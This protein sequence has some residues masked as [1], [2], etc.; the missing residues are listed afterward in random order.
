[1]S[2]PRRHATEP[3]P[4]TGFVPRAAVAVFAIGVA[5]VVRV[6]L[7]RTL[8]GRNTFLL[9]EPAIAIAAWYGGRVSGFTATVAAVVV[10]LALYVRPEGGLPAWPDT[11][12]LLLF[13]VNGVLITLLSSGLRSA[14]QRERGARRVAEESARRNDDLQRLSLALN[15]PLAPKALAQTAIEQSVRLLGA[16][17]GVIAT[18]RSSEPKL[19]IRAGFGYTGGITSGE[20]S[21]DP[22]SMLGGVVA[23]GE[24]V[25]LRGRV[26]RASRYPDLAARFQADGDSIILPLLYQDAATGAIYLNFDGRTNYGTSDREFLRS[27]GAQCGSALER[28]LLIEQAAAM[29]VKE[30]A[31]AAELDTILESIGHAVLVANDEGQIILGNTAVQRLLGRRIERIDQLPPAAADSPTP[32]NS[33]NRYLS[34]SPIRP[35]RW[36]EVSK[37]RVKAEGESSEVALVRDV[38]QVVEVDL[39]REAF[40]GVL[41]H[42]LRTPVTS[43]LLAVDLLRRSDPSNWDRALNLLADVDAELNRLY[44]IVEDLMVL[45]RSERGVLEVATEPVLV[46]RIVHDVVERMTLGDPDVPI[47]FTSAEYLPPVE[48]EPIYVQQITR[49]LISNA[50]KYG[51]NSHH[52]IEVRIS[53]SEGKVETRVLDR[54]VGLGE[55]EADKLF[56]LFYRNPKAMGIAPGAGI[57]LYVCRLLAEAMHGSMWARPREGGGAEFGFSLPVVREAFPARKRSGRRRAE[58]EGATTLQ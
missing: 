12:A 20:A 17:G 10:S 38:T 46:H 34:H 29:A 19:K 40:L 8:E 51:R 30:Q 56:R 37:F 39:Q 48:A 45:T 28:S 25:I 35:N 36:L 11:L 16:S 42:E 2:Q 22:D 4:L 27:I 54:G 57:G 3:D 41:S 1:V 50:I 26:E 58:R 18:G 52:P 49:N 55:D 44:V 33:T 21:N 32:H 23:T 13:T 53:S 24:P 5:V 31:R 47:E 15:R 14:Y 9:L 43:I 6:P 7:E